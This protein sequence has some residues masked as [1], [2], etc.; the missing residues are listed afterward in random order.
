MDGRNPS[1]ST[2]KKNNYAHGVKVFNRHDKVQEDD[3]FHSNSLLLIK[4]FA[5][6]SQKAVHKDGLLVSHRFLTANANKPRKIKELHLTFNQVVRGSTPRTLTT[7]LTRKSS[8]SKG[9]RFSIASHYYVP[10][11]TEKHI[12]SHIFLTFLT[13]FSQIFIDCVKIFFA[14]INVGIR[15]DEHFLRMPHEICCLFRGDDTTLAEIE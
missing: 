5:I 8:I 6:P 15:L 3:V 1:Q 10:L 7:Y 9:F 14:L 11:G 2:S 13:F 12:I 4:H